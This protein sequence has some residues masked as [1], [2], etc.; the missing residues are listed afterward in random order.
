MLEK[1]YYSPNLSEKSLKRG[2]IFATKIS[3]KGQL[4]ELLDKHGYTWTHRVDPL[5]LFKAVL[6]F[7]NHECCNRVSQ[8]VLEI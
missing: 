7:L 3:D 4:G 2:L 1:E 8:K 5:G 6:Y